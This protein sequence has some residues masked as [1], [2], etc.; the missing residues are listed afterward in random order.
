M[1]IS[2]DVFVFT[3]RFHFPF[4][5]FCNAWTDIDID[6]M[7]NEK[8]ESRIWWHIQMRKNQQNEV[9]SNV[10]C[11]KQEFILIAKPTRFFQFRCRT[12]YWCFRL[13]FN[14]VFVC[15]FCFPTNWI[16]ANGKKFVLFSIKFN[17]HQNICYTCRLNSYSHEN[18]ERRKCVN[19]I[20][21]NKTIEKNSQSQLADVQATQKKRKSRQK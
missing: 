4:Q 18:D 8:T 9:L 2:F 16:E 6:L 19:K 15:F 17:K 10:V 1:S 20:I 12:C 5:T 7:T 14:F 13:C 11:K 3:D 21:I